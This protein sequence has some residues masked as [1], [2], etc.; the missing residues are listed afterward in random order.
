MTASAKQA[1]FAVSQKIIHWIMAVLLMLDLFVAQKFGNP[2]ELADRLESRVDHSTLGTIV[3]V[4]FV[5]RL[6]LRFR[7]GGAALPP[8]MP[9]WQQ[10]L[11]HW[12]HVALY[13]LIG[14]LL[15]SG[16]A[17]AVNA[18][19]P[20]TLFG[21]F[22]ITLGQTQD[23]TFRFVRQFHEFA[24]DAMIALIGLHILAALYHGIIKRDGTT[25]RMLAFWRTARHDTKTTNNS[26]T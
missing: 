24:T 8:S 7:Y 17:T 3:C 11:A 26:T 25:G 1:D 13:V 14:F 21:Q 15:L 22:D 9:N 16:M 10:Q 4:L 6:L 2:M 23:D 18:T 12:A 5:I 20:I 19:N